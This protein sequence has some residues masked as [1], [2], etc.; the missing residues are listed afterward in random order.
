M[1][2]F[3]NEIVY[4]EHLEIHLTDQLKKTGVRVN[5]VTVGG[6]VQ[7]ANMAQA[8]SSETNSSCYLRIKMQN[9]QLLI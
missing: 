6:S 7:I 3:T 9:S 4:Y 8:M 2:T 5:L 1:Q